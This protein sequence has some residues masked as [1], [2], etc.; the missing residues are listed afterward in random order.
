[1]FC[2]ALPI[3]ENQAD[4]K[5]YQVAKASEHFALDR[6]IITDRTNVLGVVIENDVDHNQVE[7]YMGAND[8]TFLTSISMSG[9][10]MVS[11][12]RFKSADG[13]LLA[14]LALS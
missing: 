7:T 14:K 10:C 3:N 12:F 8:G 2:F 5:D 6:D 4:R 11:F 13:I 9:S 1:M